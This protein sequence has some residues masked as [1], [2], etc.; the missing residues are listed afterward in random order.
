MNLGEIQLFNGPNQLTGLGSLATGSV[1][2]YPISNCFDDNVNSFC[3]SDDYGRN[4]WL[5]IDVTGL[6]FDKVVIY[7]RQDCCSFRIVGAR[8]AIIT[9]TGL[10]SWQST[11]ATES[12]EYTFYTIPMPTAEPTSPRYRKYRVRIYVLCFTTHLSNAF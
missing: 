5:Q 8:I 10:V 12:L 11:F 1:S 9:S 7:N 6:V 3:H 4:P 2:G